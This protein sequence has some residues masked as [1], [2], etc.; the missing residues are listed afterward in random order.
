MQL[1]NYNGTPSSTVTILDGIRTKFPNS[2]III[3]KGLGYTFTGNFN[4]TKLTI[5]L[6]EG[7]FVQSNPA[8]GNFLC[9]FDSMSDIALNLNVVIK[10]KAQLQ[11]VKSGFRN[12]GTTVTTGNFQDYKSINIHNY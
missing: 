8:S 7:V 6:E 2:E 3:Q 10:D 1:G 5:I 9:D 11:L 4:Y 12:A